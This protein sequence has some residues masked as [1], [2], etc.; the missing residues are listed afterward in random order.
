MTQRI[1]K[2]GYSRLPQPQPHTEHRN[3]YKQLLDGAGDK[4][5]Y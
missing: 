1:K 3:L 4:E 5:E 2:Y